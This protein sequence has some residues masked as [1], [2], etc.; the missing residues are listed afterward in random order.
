MADKYAT[1]DEV[2]AELRI[3]P[4]TARRAILDGRI[5]G[6]QVNG[7]HS[8]WRI[9]RRGLRELLVKSRSPGDAADSAAE[10]NQDQVSKAA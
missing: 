4:S 5:D 9:P 7:P 1:L 6:F 8:V 2:A 10:G 3:S